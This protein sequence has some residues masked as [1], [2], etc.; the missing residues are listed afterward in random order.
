MSK[1]IESDNKTK[2]D[3]FYSNSKAEIIINQSAIEDIFES[4]YTTFIS[5]IKK[6]LG[7]G[8]GWI[9][10]LVIDYNIIISKYNP[11]AR[12]SYIK[13]PKELDHP[14]KRLVNI[15]NIDDNECFKRLLVR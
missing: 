4:L 3:T 2:Y 1:K 9:I 12:N 14:R 6:S 13:L 15:Q 10:E 11:L 8:S 7:K 5:N